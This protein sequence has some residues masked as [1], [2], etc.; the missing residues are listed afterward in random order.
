MQSKTLQNKADFVQAL[1]F[2][3]NVLHVDNTPVYT[4]QLAVL[5]THPAPLVTQRVKN[6]LHSVL[7]LSVFAA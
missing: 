5:S 4:L 6:V 3:V 1:P 2:Y 7:D